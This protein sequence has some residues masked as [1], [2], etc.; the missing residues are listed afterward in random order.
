[1]WKGTGFGPGASSSSGDPLR[2]E[3]SGKW[4][5]QK[6]AEEM[7]LLQRLQLVQEEARMYQEAILRR[8]RAAQATQPA[9]ATQS[10]QAA[11]PSQ[12]V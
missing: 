2:R 6:E 10:A 3:I 1:M 9:Q 5:S 8:L 11:Q 7:L 4:D 12:Q